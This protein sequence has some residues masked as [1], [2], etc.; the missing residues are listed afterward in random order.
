M[1]FVGIFFFW[2]SSESTQD[3]YGVA[4]YKAVELMICLE[5]HPFNIR[6]LK[7]TKANSFC[8]SSPTSSTAMVV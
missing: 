5:M 6:M 2:I 1:H 7:V 8:L 3:E 4:A